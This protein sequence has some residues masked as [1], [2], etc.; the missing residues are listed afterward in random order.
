V[1][2]VVILLG[3]TLGLVVVVPAVL[4]ALVVG[5]WVCNLFPIKGR[6]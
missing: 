2:R 1:W 3:I 5:L 6:G 4:V